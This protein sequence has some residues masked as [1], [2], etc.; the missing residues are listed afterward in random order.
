MMLRRSFLAMLG[1]GAG[2]A[3]SAAKS[4]APVIA[5][6]PVVAPVVGNVT[7]AVTVPDY[8]VRMPVRI[9]LTREQVEFCEAIGMHPVDYA[10]NLIELSKEGK[11]ETSSVNM[12]LEAELGKM[13]PKETQA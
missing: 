1:I 8:T 5:D 11:L 9:S 2:A 12:Q 6:A 10:R 4:V 13:K 7:T 3:T